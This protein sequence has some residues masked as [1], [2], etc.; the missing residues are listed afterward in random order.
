MKEI[1]K[2]VL[3][4][5]LICGISGFVLAYVK[6]LTAEPIEYAKIKNVKEPA[7]K[8]VLGGY[9]NDPIKDRISFPVGADKYG[10]PLSL[11]VFP[12][13]K[14]G[15]TFA[16]AFES[17][18]KGYKGP[19]GV[20]VGIEVNDNKLTGISVVAHTETPGLGARITETAFTDPFKGLSLEKDL[21][22][23]SVQAIS[24]ATI[25][26]VAVLAAVNGARETLAKHRDKMVN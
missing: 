10:R 1:A 21:G 8:A 5:G 11:V 20:M 9:D 6:E 15:K 17:T 13:K 19:V 14:A 26:T 16:V 18:A 2:L 4:L 7:V 12:A 25:S 3:V 24:G 23:D 22:K